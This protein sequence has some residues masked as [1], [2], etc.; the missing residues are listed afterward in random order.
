MC[1]LMTS[2]DRVLCAFAHEEPD[3]VP[4]WFGA[5]PEF[6]A[7]AKRH[8]GIRTTEDLR[9][10]MGDDFRR[11]TAPYA[12][13]AHRHPSL[14]LPE[15]AACR[16]VFG[17]EHRGIGC[18][19]P[20]DPPLANAGLRAIHAY[21]WPQAEWVDTSQLRSQAL[22]WKRQFA[23]LGGDWSPFWHDANELL[24]MQR[25]MCYLHDSPEIVDAV[26]DHVLQYYLQVNQQIFEAA[27]DLIDV[28][29]IGND[30]GSQAGPLIGPAL[31]RRFIV[32]NLRRLAG[33]GHDY[34]IKVM[35]HCCGSFA[36]LMP[37]MIEAGVDGLQALQP[38]T[39]EMQPA[40][41]KARFGKQLVF[42][43]CIDSQHVLIEGTPELVRRR[44]R[45]VLEIMKAGGGYI[46][47]ATHDFI[48]EETPV[49]NVLAMFDASRE[50][51]CYDRR[52]INQSR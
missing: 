11:I 21:S 14:G 44:T 19:I 48:L 7:K 4:A 49:E 42:N 34:G 13:P 29:F 18:G 39:P 31:F 20:V 3:R 26:L 46:V 38:C 36:P 6:I 25:L 10:R 2:R 43:G 12:G 47:S 40:E 45:D 41:L 28:F 35:M 52:S 9:V 1:V 17:V 22:L 33:L 30:F 32:P 5:S 8:C 23:I 16:T 24:G 50:Y 27:A 37:A 51:G 15:G